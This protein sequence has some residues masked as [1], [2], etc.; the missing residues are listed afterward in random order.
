MAKYISRLLHDLAVL[1]LVAGIAE[2]G[3]GLV[4]RVVDEDV[5]V[6]EEEDARAAVLAGRGSSGRSRASSRSG[7]RRRSCP[8]R[9]P[10]SA[11]CDFLP[12]Q[13]R[14]DRA[15][16]GDLLVVAWAFAAQVVEGVDR[17]AR[18]ASAL[19]QPLGRR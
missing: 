19:D 1:D 18:R 7:R 5:A 16:D 3:E 14:L 17:T 12:L 9:S 8:C 2:G 6:G 13:D 10:S 15:V 4:L 11:G